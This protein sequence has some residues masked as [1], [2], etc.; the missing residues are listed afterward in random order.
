[1]TTAFIVSFV[2]LA[3]LTAARLQLRSAADGFDRRQAGLLAAA[4][5][6]HAVAALHYNADWRTA[7]AFGVEYPSPPVAANGGTFTWRLIDLGSARRRLDGIGRVGAAQVIQSVELGPAASPFLTCA[8]LCDGELRLDGLTEV[9]TASGAPACTNNRVRN[10]GV[11]VADVEAQ[12]SSGSG[13]YL[14]TQTIPAT[15]RPLPAPEG[16]LDYYLRR[17]TMLDEALFADGSGGLSIRN[18]VLSPAANPFGPVNP[19]GIYIVNCA[20]KSLRISHSRI[21]GTLV[22]LDPRPD[23]GAQI[24]DEINWEPACPH[25]PALLVRGSL[26]LKMTTMPLSELTL[27]V[28]FNPPGTPWKRQTDSQLDDQYP[29]AIA[30][31]VYATGD[32]VCDGSHVDATTA[33]QGVLIA[34]GMIRL[35]DSAHLTMTYDPVPAGSPPPGFDSVAPNAILPG[36]WRRTASE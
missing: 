19:E 25:Y 28:N 5:I 18:V 11:I 2:G 21:V 16:V 32:V 23:R 1:M 3:G 35:T 4:A 31:I 17:G 27:G 15:V 29:S 10:D 22:V 6:E 34:D 14:G 7:Y 33:M 20:G 8:L 24:V 26:R 12:S 13:I 9:L 36:T 30:G